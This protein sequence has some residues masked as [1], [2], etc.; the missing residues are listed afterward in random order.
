ME[1]LTKAQFPNIVKF[2]TKLQSLKLLVLK[3]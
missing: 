1:R 2:L 3:C